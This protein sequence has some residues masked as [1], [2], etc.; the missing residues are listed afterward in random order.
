M[1]A[2]KITQLPSITTPN[3]TGLTIVVDSGTTYNTTLESLKNV[4]VDGQEHTFEGNQTITGNL[5]VNGQIINTETIPNVTYAELL[6]L[7]NTSGLTPLSYYLLTDFATTHWFLDG[8]GFECNDGVPNVG[9]IEPLILF[10]TTSDSISFKVYSTIYHND[11]IEYNWDIS[12]FEFDDA[13]N[14]VPNFK[15]AVTYRREVNRNN[16]AGWDIR[17]VKY[18]KWQSTAPTWDSGTTYYFKEIVIRNS[19]LYVCLYENIN[20]DP[21]LISS[22]NEWSQLLN[23]TTNIHWNSNSTGIIF[24]GIFIPSGPSYYDFYTMELNDSASFNNII[25]PAILTPFINSQSSLTNIILLGVSNYIT[26][27]DGC[28]ILTI[29]S[30]SS[31]IDLRM[32]VSRMIIGRNC[33]N[34]L[35]RP[36][37]NRLIFADNVFD[38]DFYSSCN[39]NL[40]GKTC[41]DITFKINCGNISLGYGCRSIILGPGVDTVSMA[42]YSNNISIA[43]DSRYIEFIGISSG[44][45]IGTKCFGMSILLSTNIA[46]D[47][48]CHDLR[49]P[50]NSLNSKFESG[51]D[52]DCTGSTHIVQPYNSTIF[53]NAGGNVKL[54]YYDASNVSQVVDINV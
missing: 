40:L 38:V 3:L 43:G 8:E 29:G 21:S 35:I 44:V 42:G 20:R 5:T 7:I 49:I 41:N 11:E 33:R 51:I 47:S 53:R 52:G 10:A 27:K 34:L 24:A 46:I 6:M 30:G 32:G 26:I 15:G 16:S 18:R 14:T 37:C 13:F 39:N 19:I 1:E 45:N 22:I 36:N 31:K 48:G 54:R 9:P 12:D 25:A 28:Q 2:K 17:A 4:L 50:M 23:L